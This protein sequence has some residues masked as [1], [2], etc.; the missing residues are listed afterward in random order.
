MTEV[1][2]P[3]TGVEAVIGDTCA[4][5][6]FDKT[7]TRI[8]LYNILHGGLPI[9]PYESKDLNATKI[10]NAKKYVG[11][12]NK[13]KKCDEKEYAEY[14]KDFAEYIFGGASKIKMLNNFLQLLK[15]DGIKLYIISNGYIEDI[16]SLLKHAEI[17]PKLFKKIFGNV[18]YSDLVYVWSSDT[19]EYE[20]TI[21]SSGEGSKF[22]TIANGLE[23]D[24]KN[25]PITFIDDDQ[26]EYEAMSKLGIKTLGG[27]LTLKE[28]FPDEGIGEN[29]I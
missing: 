19:N 1:K 27:G 18:D 9:V 15:S 16:I 14:G 5:F 8:H 29:E 13:T 25:S 7:L 26:L 20:E 17:D 28:K 22:W 2:I 24:C 23:N 4:I 3:E 11:C 6:D 10:E 12:L 21:I